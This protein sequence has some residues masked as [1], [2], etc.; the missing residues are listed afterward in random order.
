MKG[1]AWLERIIRSQPIESGG[2]AVLVNLASGT[3]IWL[4]ELLL[5][6]LVISSSTL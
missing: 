3:P 1:P 5:N 6:P 4:L 2:L